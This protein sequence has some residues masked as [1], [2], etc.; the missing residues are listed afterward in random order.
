ML[1]MLSIQ[2]LKISGEF[3]DIGQFFV[4]TDLFGILPEII[5]TVTALSVL[6]LEMVRVFHPR[7]ILTVAA[8]GLLLAGAVAVSYTHLTLPTIYSV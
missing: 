8:L 6:T 7:I 5:L 4:V 1:M 3:M 2:F